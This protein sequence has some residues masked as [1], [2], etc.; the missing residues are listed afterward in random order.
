MSNKNHSQKLSKNIKSTIP[1]VL[2]VIALNTTMKVSPNIPHKTKTKFRV[3]LTIQTPSTRTT[4]IPTSIPP[5][6]KN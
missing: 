2:L 1:K 3:T 4:T 6:T 5:A